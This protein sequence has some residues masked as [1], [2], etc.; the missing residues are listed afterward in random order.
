MPRA[1]LEKLKSRLKPALQEPATA[2]V[3]GICFIIGVAESI[4]WGRTAL[5]DMIPLWAMLILL[6]YD[7]FTQPSEAQSPNIQDSPTEA[8]QPVTMPPPAVC[9]HTQRSGCPTGA[10]L[11]LLI[12]AAVMAPSIAFAKCATV[13][14]NGQLTHS[15][16]NNATMALRNISLALLAISVLTYKSGWHTAIRHW[17]LPTMSLIVIPFY[18][19]LLLEFSFP[20]RLVSTNIAVGF[21]RLLSFNITN[22]GTTLLWNGNEL[23]I[24]DACSGISLLGL[25]LF[26]A[27]WLIR[28][29]TAPAWQK[30]CWL[31]MLLLWIMLSNTLRLLLTLFGYMIWGEVIFSSIPH[32]ILGCFFVICCSLLLWFSSGKLF[33]S[34]TNQT[35]T[36]Q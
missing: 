5:D 32:F 21:L 35:E 2:S 24:T 7:H 9:E 1:L 20:L 3:L 17:T 19:L 31:S 13:Q 25:L 27:Y 8:I 29:V 10:W 23:A 12:S 14:A 30:Y 15:I 4:L 36:E 16:G 11:I 6:F 34:D 22:N 18:E 28:K 33:K 26:I